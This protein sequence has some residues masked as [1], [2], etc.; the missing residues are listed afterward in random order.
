MRVYLTTNRND[1]DGKVE[2]TREGMVVNCWTNNL[3]YMQEN[4]MHCGS[5][6]NA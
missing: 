4:G 3:E 5:G 1:L 2:D 6:G